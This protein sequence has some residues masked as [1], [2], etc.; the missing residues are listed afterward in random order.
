MDIT[1]SLAIKRNNRY[2]TLNGLH[3]LGLY[4]EIPVTIENTKLTILQRVI[5]YRSIAIHRLLVF[6]CVYRKLCRAGGE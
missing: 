5:S 2:N 6:S 4:L 3:E 1:V